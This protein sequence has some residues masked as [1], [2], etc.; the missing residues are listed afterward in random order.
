MR[1]CVECYICVLHICMCVVF[2]DGAYVH[3][4]VHVCICVRISVCVCAYVCM[5]T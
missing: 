5:C 3:V 2:A 1:K 4:C